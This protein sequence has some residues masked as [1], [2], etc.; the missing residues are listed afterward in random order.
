MKRIILIL[1][2]VLITSTAFGETF[3]IYNT[4]TKEVYSL[5]NEDD[6]QMP[7]TGYTKE[8]LKDNLKDI[9][10]QFHPTKYLWKE[11][12]FVANMKKL[13]DEANAQMIAEEKA[14]EE[15]LIQE[16]LRQT[17]IT[18]LKAKGIIFKYADK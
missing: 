7:A 1:A 13:S 5:S 12:R 15:K 11:K 9:E 4:T 6:C 18:T 10:L 14:Q 3:L 16:E 17:A 2:F 8:I